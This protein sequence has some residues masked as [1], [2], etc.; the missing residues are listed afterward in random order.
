MPNYP[1]MARAAAAQYGLGPWFVTQIKDES[2]FNPTAGSSA[3]A[4]GIAQFMPGTAAAM[5]VDP[6]NP[7][8]ALNGA[9][10]LDA[11]NIKKYGSVAR[12]LSAYNS[13]KPD[14]YL[15]P[16]FANGQTTRYVKNILGSSNPA[17]KSVA[18][19]MAPTNTS[20]AASGGTS[21]QNILAQLMLT[22]SAQTAAGG[23]ADSGSLLAMA[24]LRNQLGAAQQVYG[25]QT[26]TMVQPAQAGS[27]AALKGF[28]MDD[29]VVHGTGVGGGHPTEGL[30]GYPAHDYFAPA[31]SPTVAPVAGKVVKLSG[32]DPALGPIQGPHGPLGWS[33]YIQGTDG[34]TYYLTHMGSRDVKIGE[35]VKA[36]QPIG[37]V[38]NYA[39]YGTPSHIHMGV[40]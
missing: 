27:A 18:S 22:Q 5:G 23:P 34:H 9:A 19:A 2:G 8:Q 14:A 15:D 16:N 13:G 29:P 36:G 33:A 17:V 39:K 20:P 11:Q 24:M 28:R 30:P 26:P 1:A 35:T 25:S 3:G 40:H 12:A 4:K 6:M 32:H 21:P 7:Q 38:A 10:R 37:T 31:G